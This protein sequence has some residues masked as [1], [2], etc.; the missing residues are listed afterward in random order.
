M[1]P[2]LASRR[3]L[4]IEDIL[5]SA[6]VLSW[7]E[8]LDSSHKGVVHVE[9]GTAPEPSL[10]YLKIWLSTTR[11]KWDLI[12]EYW[13]S[14]GSS[15]LPAAGLTFSNGYHSAHLAHML[16]DVMRRHGGIA[17]S[18]S[19]ETSVGL[20]MVG[21][22]TEGDTLEASDRMSKAYERL[23]LAFAATAGGAA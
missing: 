18:L 7:K 2:Y 17:G 10:Q 23:G 21:P 12:C 11:G 1:I 15:S 22:P 9:Y 16:E 14:R 8:L 3:R 5:E 13:M 19:G 6:V 4:Q 20:I